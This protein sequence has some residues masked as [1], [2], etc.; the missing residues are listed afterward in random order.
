A[1]AIAARYQAL[2]VV[3][4]CGSIVATPDGRC[5]VNT[6]GNPGLASAGTGDVLSGLIVALLAQGWPALEALLAGVHLHG[7]AADACVATGQGPVGLTAGEIIDSAR[8]CLNRWIA[9]GR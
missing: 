2:V 8:A 1:L 3:K 9:H 6:T 4:G 5:F 7:T